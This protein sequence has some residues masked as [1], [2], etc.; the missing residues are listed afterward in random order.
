MGYPTEEKDKMWSDLYNCTFY[1]SYHLR[2]S[3]ANLASVGTSGISNE[4]AKNLPYPTVP[5]PDSEDDSLIMLDVWH[6][7][8]CLGTL[9]RMMY[10]EVWPKIWTKHE[11]GRIN[12]DTV[13]MLHIG[14]WPFSSPSLFLALEL[15]S[16]KIT[17]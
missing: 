12:Y 17:A 6:Q 11:D 9:R 13:E 2:I 7:L 1:L 5:V 4:E 16:P 15:T 8:H 3:Y 14:I 10:P